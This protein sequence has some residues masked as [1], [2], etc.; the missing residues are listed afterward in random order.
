MY[1]NLTDEDRFFEVF[2]LVEDPELLKK[3]L[4]AF[5]TKK[6]L[7]AFFLRL[8]ALCMLR[9]GLSY[10]QI[11]AHTGLSPNTISRLA[12]TMSEKNNPID[13]T[14]RKFTKKIKTYRE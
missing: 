12:K 4:M 11:R 3:F 2:D 14:L 6:E 9:D 1:W 10:S 7:D 8:K 13:L 5:L